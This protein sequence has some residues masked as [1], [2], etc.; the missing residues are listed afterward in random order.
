MIASRLG[1]PDVLS[2]GS[3]GCLYVTCSVLHYVLGELP[4]HLT[5]HAPYQVFR[6][7]LDTEGVAGR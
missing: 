5:E 3:D 1:W 4:S 6:I 2:F 7:K